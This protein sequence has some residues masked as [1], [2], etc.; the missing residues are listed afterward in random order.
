MSIIFGS[1]SDSRTGQGKVPLERKKNS[2]RSK[3]WKKIEYQWSWWNNWLWKG[4]KFRDS[5][6]QL[7]VV[8][9]WLSCSRAGFIF[10]QSISHWLS[11]YLKRVLK[12]SRPTLF[13]KNRTPTIVASVRF[14]S[15]I[16]KK[17]LV[18]VLAK[19]IQRYEK[20]RI[21]RCDTWCAQ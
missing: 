13:T 2:E 11:I 12:F 6:R 10:G 1:G 19:L 3:C 18:F 16:N 17:L 7:G 20:A 4:K 5:G 8:S 9:R 15:I 14:L 21:I